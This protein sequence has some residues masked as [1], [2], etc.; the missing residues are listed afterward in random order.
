MPCCDFHLSSNVIVSRVCE[1][2]AGECGKPVRNSVAYTAQPDRRH[3]A[4][5]GSKHNKQRNLCLSQL[6]NSNPNR[7]SPSHTPPIPSSL[8]LSSPPTQHSSR[9]SH[10]LYPKQA[11]IS[12]S[13]PPT[14]LHTTSPPKIPAAPSPPARNPATYYPQSQN[15]SS[16]PSPS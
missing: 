10:P 13:T 5:P 3:A 12:P 16:P 15:L 6:K 11:A 7:K 9:N 1:F 2:C 4:M 14:R 8:P